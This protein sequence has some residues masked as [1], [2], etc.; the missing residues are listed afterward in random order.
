[1]C[2]IT[3][4]CCIMNSEYL[5][6]GDISWLTQE[7]NISCQSANFDVTGCS[8]GEGDLLELFSDSVDS[9]VVSLEEDNGR[10]TSIK[11][12][13]LYDGVVAEDISSDEELDRM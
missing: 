5:D 6:D 9:N 7:S 12:T 3:G 8:E 10:E 2:V 4:I 11:G 1:M 13:V